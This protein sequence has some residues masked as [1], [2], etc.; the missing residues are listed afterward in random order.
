MPE[1]EAGE[2]TQLLESWSCGDKAAL[3]HLMPIIHRELRRRAAAYLR[4]ERCDHTLQPTALV[5]EAY[6]RL[7]DQDKVQCHSRAQFFA[8]AANVMRQILVD[9]ARNHRASKRGGGN[10]VALGEAEDCAQR[11][12]FDLVAL[13]RALDWLARFD[14]RQSRVVEL[15]FF[16]GLTEQEIAEQL[17]V[18]AI[19]VKRDW[20]IARAAL[21]H[22]MGGGALG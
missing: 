9:H 8:I 11:E 17:E 7:V 6:L 16:G 1:A 3:N 5:H 18:S 22:Q 14:P 19:T 12:E 15:R 2:V 20:R 4:R 13:D 21:H 10:K